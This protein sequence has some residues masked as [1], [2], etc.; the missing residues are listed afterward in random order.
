MP[1]SVTSVAHLNMQAHV[2]RGDNSFLNGHAFTQYNGGASVTIGDSDHGSAKWWFAICY[3]QWVFYDHG[4]TI[5][6]IANDV[7]FQISFTEL[8]ALSTY[9][10]RGDG[11]TIPS[12]SIIVSFSNA[13][14]HY[15]GWRPN[16]SPGAR[17][18]SWFAMGV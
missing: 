1:I 10:F 17:Y 12:L 3:Q 8:F 6:G 11:G 7:T 5:P 13:G 18:V 16:S 14:F 2:Q 9:A 4:S 15:E